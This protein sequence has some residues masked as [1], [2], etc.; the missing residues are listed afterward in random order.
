[1]VES[2]LVHLEM[3]C[4]AVGC[5]GVTVTVAENGGGGVAVKAWVLLR[6]GV[7]VGG[8]VTLVMV[9]VSMNVWDG[10][11]RTVRLFVVVTSLESAM[12][13][14]PIARDDERVP[15]ASSSLSDSDELSVNEGREIVTV[16][17][18]DSDTSDKVRLRDGRV[19]VEVGSSENESLTVTGDV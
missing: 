15:V 13:F 19:S 1:M 2:E 16:Y 8:G 10:E 9:D 12:L 6:G 5:D 4:R 7:I 14:V 11:A 3:V 18:H 17:S